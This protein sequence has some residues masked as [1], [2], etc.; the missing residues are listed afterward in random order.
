M[1]SFGRISGYIQNTN[2]FQAQ[3][4]SSLS[5]FLDDMLIKLEWRLNIYFN[6]DILVLHVLDPG[7][8]MRGLKSLEFDKRKVYN[9][10]RK[11]SQRFDPSI[12]EDYSRKM[13][14]RKEF[15]EYLLLIRDDNF[16]P[17][18]DPFVYWSCQSE[19]DFEPNSTLGKLAVRILSAPASAADIERI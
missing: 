6:I 16:T 8:G 3:P 10:I 9:I 11:V 17:P 2:V 14:L 13:A 5:G 4:S 12:A 18:D 7:L 19:L 15:V 1:Q